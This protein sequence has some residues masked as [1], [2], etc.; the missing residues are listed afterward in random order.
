MA[1]ESNTKV[2]YNACQDGDTPKI[3]D[4]LKK[5]VNI[6]EIGRN[7][8]C[9]PLGIAA[10]NGRLKIV[11]LFLQHK[12]DINKTGTDGSIL[13]WNAV[14]KGYFKVVRYF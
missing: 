5:R 11:E 6:N 3:H 2:L 1:D 7:W 9:I 14:T 4:L 8:Q 12:V 10:I 13:L